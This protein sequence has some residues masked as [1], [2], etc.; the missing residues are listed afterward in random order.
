MIGINS[1]TIQIGSRLAYSHITTENA[2]DKAGIV[3]SNQAN[4]ASTN[5]NI[6]AEAQEKLAQDKSAFGQ[7]LTQ[8]NEMKPEQ[9]AKSAKAEAESKAL[10]KLIEETQKK[11]KETQEKLRR[12]KNDNSEEAKQEQA[13]L[14]SQVMLLNGVLISLFG[15]KFDALKQ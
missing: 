2:A 9:S 15:K 1:S 10:D 11:I 6:S 7:S 3:S 14:E 4:V 8:K 13:L 5:V 12:L